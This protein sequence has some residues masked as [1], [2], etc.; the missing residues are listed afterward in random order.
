MALESFFV[1]SECEFR[2]SPLARGPI[3]P[4]IKY[5]HA[6]VSKNLNVDLLIGWV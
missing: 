1:S 2:G 5:T 4:M 3:V 6:A